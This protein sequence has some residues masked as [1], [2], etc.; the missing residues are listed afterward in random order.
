MTENISVDNKKITIFK[1]YTLILVKK[2]GYQSES[3]SSSSMSGSGKRSF[4]VFTLGSEL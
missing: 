3:L 1:T 2:K 4:N